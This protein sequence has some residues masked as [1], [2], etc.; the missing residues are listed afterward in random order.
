[1]TDNGWNPWKITA[2]GLSVVVVTALVTGL[3]VANWTGTERDHVA[4][5]KPAAKS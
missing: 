1:M 3:V 2:I 5:E 4:V